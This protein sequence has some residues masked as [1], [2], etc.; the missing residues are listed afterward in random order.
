MNIFKALHFLGLTNLT[1][2]QV[3][4][5][6]VLLDGK[7]SKARPNTNASNIAFEYGRLYRQVSLIEFLVIG[8][9]LSTMVA[10]LLPAVQSARESARR[11][12]CY[13]NLKLLGLATNSYTSNYGVLPPMS[14]KPP[15]T[16]SDTDFYWSW[17]VLLLSGLER[18]DLLN[19]VNFDLSP[20][21]PHSATVGRV[22]VAS[23]LC[24]SDAVAQARSSSW[25]TTNYVGNYGGPGQ[26][27]AYSGT[28]VPLEDLKLNG[29]IENAG[30]GGEVGPVSIQSITDGLSNTGL[31]SEHLVGLPNDGPI[32]VDSTDANRGIFEGRDSS[33]IDTGINGALAFKSGCTSIPRSTTTRLTKIIGSN[34]LTAYPVHVALTNYHHLNAPNS[35]HCANP[36]DT[37]AVEFVGPTGA[38]SA[39]S[40]HSGGVNV[41]FTDGSV[42]FV[43]DTVS[44]TTWWS[45]GSR[46]LGEMI[47]KDSY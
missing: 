23:L 22:Q 20:I 21:G 43:K 37:L 32:S 42:R 30:W 40:N 24:P 9:I 10:L 31:F 38:A 35:F 5:L 15:R 29:A 13:N 3:N 12:Q 17:T 27:K 11:A 41:A 2:E 8:G 16:D 14:M 7:S 19:S 46:N 39:N 33:G 18:P 1:D 44:R 36:S 25:G 26:M 6:G 34:W 4:R 47:S 45:L 28:I